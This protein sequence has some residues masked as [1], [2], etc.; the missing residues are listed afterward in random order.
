MAQIVV[1]ANVA[2]PNGPNLAFNQIIDVDAYDKIDVAVPA[3]PTATT[4]KKVE[5][6]NGTGDVLFIAITADAYSEKLTYKINAGTTVRKLDQ[7]HLFM[8]KGGVSLF[9]AAPA[10]LLF[11]NPATGTNANVQILIGRDATP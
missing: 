10:T 5:L 6:V 2:V 8:G 3:Q 4:D 11:S 7:P 1:S 9:D